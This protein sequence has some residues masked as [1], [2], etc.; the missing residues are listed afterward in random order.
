VVFL[1]GIFYCQEKLIDNILSR[2]SYRAMP[3]CRLAADWRN[4]KGE[5]KV[6]M[7]KNAW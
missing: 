5:E 4:N 7:S 1:K 2:H 3:I 6:S